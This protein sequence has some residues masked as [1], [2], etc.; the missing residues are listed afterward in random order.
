MCLG[1]RQEGYN[2]WV[3][4]DY[5]TQRK[6]RKR[7]PG[8]TAVPRVPPAAVSEPEQAVNAE[9]PMGPVTSSLL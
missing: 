6:M 4:I 7:V 1:Q 9:R 8:R 3:L 5:Y 2:S